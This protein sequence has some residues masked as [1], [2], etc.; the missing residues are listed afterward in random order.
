MSDFP[1]NIVAIALGQDHTLAVTS[2]GYILSW[3]H[4]RFAQLGYA[5]DPPEKP[6]VAGFA[7]DEQ[8][9][10]V[11]PKRIVGSLKKEFV[12]GVAA[13]R[14]SSAC[15]TEDSLFTWGTN[16]GHLGYDKAANPIQ[17]QPR[18]V[19]GMTQPVIDVALTVSVCARQRVNIS[20]RRH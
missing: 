13:G 5:F 14:M 17:V 7:K 8:E 3:G 18:K 6:V 10:Q 16:A 15:W 2:G 4:N 9:V 19:T 20:L 1:H 11:S 12:M